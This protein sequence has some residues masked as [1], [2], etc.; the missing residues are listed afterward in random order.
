LLNGQFDDETD[1]LPSDWLNIGGAFAWQADNSNI[2]ND[3][4]DTGVLFNGHSPGGG[5]LKIWGDYGANTMS[6]GESV[7]YQEFVS[8]ANWSPA[9]KIFWL[10]AWS[11]I[12]DQDPLLGTAEAY[13]MIRCFGNNYSM[14]GEEMSQILDLNSQQNSWRKISTW[15]ECT[16]GATLVQAVLVFKQHNQNTDHGVVYFDDVTFTE[17][18]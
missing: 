1:G 5:A 6:Y 8:D 2:V 7:V 4:G 13:V 12:S 11:F 3:D 10:D 9:N 17:V 18:Q 14:E 16:G 15:V